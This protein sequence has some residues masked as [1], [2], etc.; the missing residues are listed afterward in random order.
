MSDPLRYPL[1]TLAEALAKPQSFEQSRSDIAAFP[2][3]IR[4]RVQGLTPKQ[5]RAQY[6]PDSWNIRQ[7]V[8][9]CADSHAHALLRI[10]RA[11]VETPPVS[12]YGYDEAATATLADYT[13]PVEP[14][15][16][17]LEG[18]HERLAALLAALTSAQREAGYFH[19]EQKRTFSVID[20][21][22]TYAWHGRHHLA[23]IDLALSEA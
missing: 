14:S 18:L 20:A 2:S 9:H 17:Q 6:R 15:L 3:L 19:H 22:T 13:L 1:G 23:H 7:L 16:L 11:L 10:K 5:L 21:A 12:I 4:Q 8:H